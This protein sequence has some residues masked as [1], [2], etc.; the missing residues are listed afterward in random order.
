MPPP[1]DF[2]TLT[3]SELTT[4]LKELR[5]GRATASKGRKT[6]RQKGESSP[7]AP[8]TKKQE[9]SGQVDLTTL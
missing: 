1:F 2:S 4:R 9:S 3:T 8:R 5:E 6:K 7:H